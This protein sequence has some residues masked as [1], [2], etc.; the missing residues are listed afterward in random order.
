MVDI[1]N[2][3]EAD[4]ILPFKPYDYQRRA[5]NKSVAF[6]NLLLPLKVGRGKTPLATWRILF[7]AMAHNVNHGLIIVPPPLVI[8]WYRWLQRITNISA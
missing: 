3:I 8:Q 7:D 2:I 5:L 4:F 1:F 6:P